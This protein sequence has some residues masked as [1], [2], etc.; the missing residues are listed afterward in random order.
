M[1]L[2]HFRPTRVVRLFCRSSCVPKNF[3]KKQLY[4]YK[5]NIFNKIV[6]N[7][8]QLFYK[9]GEFSFTRKPFNFPQKK[10]KSKR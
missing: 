2:S 7:R 1:F 3:F 5:G 6:F 9:F 8:Y 4:V 10:K